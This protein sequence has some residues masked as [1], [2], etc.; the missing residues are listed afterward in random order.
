MAVCEPVRPLSSPRISQRV[1]HLWL[2]LSCIPSR[3]TRPTEAPRYEQRANI[4]YSFFD[5]NTIHPMNTTS[6]I[7]KDRTTLLVAGR[8]ADRNKPIRQK[9]DT[10]ALV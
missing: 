2:T 10:D 7:P 5:I 3:P 4:L 6:C 9:L 8:C 1:L